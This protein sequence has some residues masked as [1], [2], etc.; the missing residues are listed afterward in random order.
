[1]KIT[2][3]YPFVILL[4]DRNFRSEKHILNKFY[5]ALETK[6]RMREKKQISSIFF[7][8]CKY[9]KKKSFFLNILD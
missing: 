8:V 2:I 5:I 4:P 1:M 9:L 6:V 3:T 7:F